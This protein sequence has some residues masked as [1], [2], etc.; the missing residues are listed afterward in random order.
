MADEKQLAYERDHK[1]AE[2]LLKFFAYEHLPPQLQKVS[3]QFA[4][5]ASWI[6]ANLPPGPER[7]V[8]LRKLLEAKDCAVRTML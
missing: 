6:A 8:S 3:A 2:N 1:P 5:L 7:T 4:A